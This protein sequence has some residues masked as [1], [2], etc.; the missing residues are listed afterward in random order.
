MIGTPI[1]M[2]LFTK[3][4][5]LVKHAQ[6]LIEINAAVSRISEL[7]IELPIGIVDVRFEYEQDVR[8]CSVCK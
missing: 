1:H 2:D 5:K 6:V 7:Q 4:R 3:G 8:F